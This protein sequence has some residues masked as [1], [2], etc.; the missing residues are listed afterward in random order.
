[1]EPT[2]SR[3]RAFTAGLLDPGK[4]A[5]QKTRQHLGSPFQVLRICAASRETSLLRSYFLGGPKAFRRTREA[6]R[7]SL[8]QK[9]GG[10]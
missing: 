9:A 4:L 7:W 2:V 10:R 1:M 5:T 3:N 8:R 6:I